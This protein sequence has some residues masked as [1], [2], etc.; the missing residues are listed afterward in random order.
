MVD[1]KQHLLTT[2]DSR[3]DDLF[4]IWPYYLLGR[5]ATGTGFNERYQGD[6][7]RR[8]DYRLPGKFPG[9]GHRPS[10]KFHT[11]MCPSIYITFKQLSGRS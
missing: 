5:K 7:R 11:G 1:A 6:G 2:H 3:C 10:G 8:W 4:P 9:R